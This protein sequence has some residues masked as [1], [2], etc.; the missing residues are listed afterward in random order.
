M[1]RMEIVVPR[2]N[3]EVVFSGFMAKMAIGLQ[4]G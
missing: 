4:N 3:G 1:D 2:A